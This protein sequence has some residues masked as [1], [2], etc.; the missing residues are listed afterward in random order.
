MTNSCL[1]LSH[2]TSVVCM[3]IKPSECVRLQ[4]SVINLYIYSIMNILMTFTEEAG[5][6]TRYCFI[7]GFCST[8]DILS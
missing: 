7:M 6:F 1:G 4:N 5:L 3:Y 8:I 2:H